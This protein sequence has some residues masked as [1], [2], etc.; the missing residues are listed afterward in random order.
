[1][2][3]VKAKTGGTAGEVISIR[4]KE[5]DRVREGDTLCKLETMKMDM[6]V[7]SPYG[8][9]VTKV[10]IRLGQSISDGDLLFEIEEE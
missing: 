7:K 2:A 5:G 9:K 10:S 1:M 4:V 3:Q 8:G 6:P